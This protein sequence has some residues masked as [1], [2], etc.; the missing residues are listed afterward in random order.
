[1]VRSGLKILLIRP[2]SF[3]L[4]GLFAFNWPPLTLLQIAAVTPKEYL[5]KIVDESFEE[6]N[7]NT[8]ADLVGITFRTLNAPRG[9]WIADEF[10]RREYPWL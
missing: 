2:D 8:D 5:V 6:V 10:R 1:M 7:F 4:R 9:Y 3:S